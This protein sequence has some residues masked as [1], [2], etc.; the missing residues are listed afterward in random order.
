MEEQARHA[1]GKDLIKKFSLLAFQL[2]GS[3]VVDARSLEVATVDF[4]IIAQTQ[5]PEL[6]DPSIPDGFSR[7][8]MET[9]LQSCPVSLRKCDEAVSNMKIGRFAQQ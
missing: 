1:I 8:I 5:D 4:R 9:V 3:S 2:Y 6:L 7:C